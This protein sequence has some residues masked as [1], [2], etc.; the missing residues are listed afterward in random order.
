LSKCFGEE[1]LKKLREM[2]LNRQGDDTLNEEPLFAGNTG[3]FAKHKE[4]TVT[5][6]QKLGIETDE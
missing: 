5:N 1:G 6:L 3:N 4:C 2:E